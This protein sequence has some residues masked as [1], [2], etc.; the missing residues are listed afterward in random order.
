MGLGLTPGQ[1]VWQK[2]LDDPKFA[3][4]PEFVR[5]AFKPYV[6]AM[7]EVLKTLLDE[8]ATDETIRQA[9]RLFSNYLK[10]NGYAEALYS[11]A[12]ELNDVEAYRERQRIALLKLEK[13]LDD[14]LEAFDTARLALDSRALKVLN[15]ND[16]TSKQDYAVPRTIGV[17]MY[18]EPQLIARAR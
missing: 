9:C 17:I 2:L 1:A 16:E 13:G 14:A 11:A 7:P 8:L 5:I 15:I 10:D 12:L 4:E 18:N 3:E 6:E